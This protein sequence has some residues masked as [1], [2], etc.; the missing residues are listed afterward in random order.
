VRR[1]S[2]WRLAEIVGPTGKVIG[3]D[4]QD[5]MIRLMKKEY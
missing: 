4:I 3:E 5:G 1:R 2:V